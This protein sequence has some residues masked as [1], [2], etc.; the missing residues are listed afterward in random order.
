MTVQD[1]RQRLR[2]AWAAVPLDPRR[3]A[4]ATAVLLELCDYDVD[5]FNEL[6]M[7]VDNTRKE[8]AGR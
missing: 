1:A 7:V 3:V 5:Q 6:A 8:G 2:E 4:S